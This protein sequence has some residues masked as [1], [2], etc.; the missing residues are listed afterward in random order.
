MP[1]LQAEDQYIGMGIYGIFILF[2]CGNL[3]YIHRMTRYSFLLVAMSWILSGCESSTTVSNPLSGK[4]TSKWQHTLDFK[5]HFKDNN[6]FQV[7]VS[8]SVQDEEIFGGYKVIK[9]TLIIWDELE[10]PLVLCN[11]SDTGFYTFY[12]RDSSLYF[13]GIKDACERRKMTLEIGLDTLTANQAK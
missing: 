8:G 2:V 4:W 13:K 1:F 12:K 6:T 5:I 9:D 7:K 3:L 10:R 11:Y